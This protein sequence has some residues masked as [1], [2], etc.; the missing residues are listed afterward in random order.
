MKKRLIGLLFIVVTVLTCCLFVSCGKTTGKHSAGENESQTE[1]LDVDL[2]NYFYEMNSDGTCTITGV[3]DKT[4]EEVYIPSCVTKIE[5]DVF[6]GCENI[7][8]VFTP[9]LE[10]W[11]SID[12]LVSTKNQDLP[13]VM[14]FRSNPFVA[15]YAA[16]N[17]F[18]LVDFYVNGVLTTDVII[19]NNVK[20]INP[21]LF[22]C[23]NVTSLE[24]PNS[25][26]EIGLGAFAFCSSITSVE[27][28][29]S[30]D[31]IGLGAF[32]FCSSLTSVVIPDSVTSIGDSAFGYCDSMTSVVIPDNVTT[33]GDWA[34]YNCDSLTSVVIGDGVTSIGDS[35]FNNCHKLVEVVNK[36]T[37][38][39]VTK[40]STDYGYLG[41]YA[42][43]VY[44]SGDA[45]I[46]KFSNDGDY[47]I[48]TDGAEKIL[49]GY[50]GAE[51]DLVLP[52]YITKINQFAFYSCESL[53]SVVIGDSVT[54]IGDWAF[55][56]C[57]SLT[58]IT[59]PDSVTSIGEDA[60]AS[61]NS[62]TSVV[63]GDGVTS[64]GDY[65][66]AWCNSLTSITIPE[67]VTSIGFYAFRNC[68]K[69]VEVIN[70]STH[71]TVIKGSED[72]GCLGYYALEVYN[73]GSG[74]TESQLLNDNGYIIYT[75]GAE[76]ILVG[77]NGAETDLVLPS[78]ITKIYQY[79]FY[80]CDSLTSVV[81]P[82]SVTTIGDWAFYN[83]DSLTSVVIGDNV[84][85][86]GDWA[87][88]DC[89]SLT[90]VVIGD[91]VTSIGK[92]AF[93]NCTSLT[94]VVIGDGATS[95]GDSA[96]SNCDSLTS[97]VIGDGVT[98]I[99]DRAFYDCNCLT[100]IYFKGSASDWVNISIGINGNDGLTSAMRYYYSE[101]EPT[102][103]GNY[104]HYDE[105]GEIAVWSEE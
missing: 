9:S 99:G 27:I 49:V 4:V 105:N 71:F 89:D 100:S 98:T 20:K 52:S 97:V 46:S 82:D 92:C 23:S 26:V 33:I 76:K 59:I 80:N 21:F 1:I 53:T 30:V 16:T 86:I 17:S 95:I 22:A 72:Y 43:A 28:P 11:C 102:A 12:F 75:D 94:S 96:F 58:R 70:K 68:Y 50:N 44:N 91:S 77:Y 35:A 57:R 79:A 29:D 104:W 25:V 6:A 87:F 40:G 64:I 66:F 73:S 51:T 13:L 45:Y 81:I 63:I 8:K 85:T 88:S 54:S 48:Y 31:K 7:N 61:C 60:F 34:F 101:I 39:T 83:C 65:A 103:S 84:T 15:K 24:M 69:L 67:S 14:Q 55:Y 74:I 18:N 62:L 56:Y 47:I 5:G 19:P 42:L 36:S 2:S 3:K 90:S 37:H 38:F 78:Y 93:Y 10:A 41:Y 32:V